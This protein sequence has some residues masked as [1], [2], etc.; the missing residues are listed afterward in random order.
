MEGRDNKPLNHIIHKCQHDP[1]EVKNVV[2]TYLASKMPE[3]FPDPINNES[4]SM[5]AEAPSVVPEK[6]LNGTLKGYVDAV[7]TLV[8]HDATTACKHEAVLV[9]GDR[10]LYVL[11]KRLTDTHVLS[12]VHC[13]SSTLNL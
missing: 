3:L 13:Q 9:N 5:R 6:C 4:S 2:C 12:Q 11:L 1:Q 8:H 7:L 10:P